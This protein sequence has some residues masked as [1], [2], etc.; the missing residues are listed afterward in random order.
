MDKMIIYESSQ[1]GFTLNEQKN[2][3]DIE[4]TIV[5]KDNERYLAAMKQLR[6][7]YNS[8]NV[9]TDVLFYV[10]KDH[11]YQIIVRQ[12]TYIDFLLSLFKY[13]FIQSISW[14]D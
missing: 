11:E 6:D 1:E 3:E 7:F 2:N 4:F 14:N 12:D 9:Y 13:K 8:D 10:H 5:I